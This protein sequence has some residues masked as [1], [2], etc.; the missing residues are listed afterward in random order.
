MRAIADDPRYC[1][2]RVC[3]AAGAEAWWD[4]VRQRRDVP[5]AISALLAGRTRVELSFS[6]AAHALAWASHVDGWSDAEQRPLH[7][8]AAP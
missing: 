5:E 2:L 8:Y 4:A 7:L 3:P 1:A 6:E